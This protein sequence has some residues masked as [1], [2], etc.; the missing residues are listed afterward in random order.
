MYM[1]KSGLSVTSESEVRSIR[2][3]VSLWDCSTDD[4]RNRSTSCQTCRAVSVWTSTDTAR[5]RGRI[6]PASIDVRVDSVLPDQ[7]ALRCT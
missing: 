7:H 1:V 6:E 2:R 3:T 4:L 5:F